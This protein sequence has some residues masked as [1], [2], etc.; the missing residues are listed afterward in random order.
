MG[1][2]L[3]IFSLVDPQASPAVIQGLPQTAHDTVAEYG[4]DSL[5]KLVFLPV[6]GHIL[7]IQKTYQRL[8]SCHIRHFCSAFLWF[9]GVCFMVLSFVSGSFILYSFMSQLCSGT[10]ILVFLQGSPSRCRISQA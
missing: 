2:S 7:V 3:L 4:E 6:K 8:S 5:H 1:H 9:Y 10:S